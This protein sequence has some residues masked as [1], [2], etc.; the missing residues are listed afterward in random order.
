MLFQKI[1]HQRAPCMSTTMIGEFELTRCAGSCSP[2]R[3]AHH[4]SAHTLRPLVTYLLTIVCCLALMQ[5]S[6]VPCVVQ[7]AAVNTDMPIIVVPIHVRWGGGDP[8]DISWL[9]C[10]FVSIPTQTAPHVVQAAAVNTDT[11]CSSHPCGHLL[12][13]VV[14]LYHCQHQLHYVLC[15]QLR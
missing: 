6:N 15:R 8:V 13:T 4:C 3:H 10:C 14:A 7:A 1:C 2:H 12:A 11:S 9:S 5:V